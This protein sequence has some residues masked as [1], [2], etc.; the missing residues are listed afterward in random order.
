MRAPALPLGGGAVAAG[1]P[2]SACHRAD[3]RAG[4][5]A[6]P[7]AAGWL[8]Q[9]GCRVPPLGA[10]QGQRRLARVGERQSDE[11]PGRRVILRDRD[12]PGV[13]RGSHIARPAQRPASALRPAG[14]GV[15]RTAG[16][17]KR[18]SPRPASG[19][20]P[21]PSPPRHLDGR[22]GVADIGP[23]EASARAAARIAAGSS[24]AAASLRT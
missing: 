11:L 13:G 1:D 18:D 20:T 6:R 12:R 5:A 3:E 19:N 17:P 23:V 2:Q 4:R 21:V 24:R 7:V 8:R 15:R 9:R 14:T 10:R 22:R 16:W